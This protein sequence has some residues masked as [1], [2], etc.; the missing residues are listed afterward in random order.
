MRGEVEARHGMH[1][2]IRVAPDTCW[3][4]HVEQIVSA[5]EPTMPQPSALQETCLPE[6]VHQPVPHTTSQPAHTEVTTSDDI[7]PE[8]PD[9]PARNSERPET[10]TEEN[11]TERRYPL[12]VRRPRQMFTPG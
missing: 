7:T 8:D 1:Y 4:R 12:R 10:A 2:D 5:R 3:R 6:V 11:V 9:M